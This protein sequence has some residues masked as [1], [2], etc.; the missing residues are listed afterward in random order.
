MSIVASILIRTGAVR[1]W[2]SYFASSA[3]VYTGSV[4]LESGN[5]IVLVSFYCS[6]CSIVC[7]SNLMNLF[8]V[9]LASGTRGLGTHIS[10]VRSV[11]MDQW[12]NDQ[13]ALMR[14]GGNDRCNAFL[15]S[16]GIITAVEPNAID[17][18]DVA[19]SSDA[20][21]QQPLIDTIR[22]KY[23]N[24][25]A[26]LYKQVLKAER[27]GLPIPTE[28]PMQTTKAAVI[29]NMKSKMVGFGS[30]PPPPTNNSEAPSHRRAMTYAV[31]AAIAVTGGV[32]ALVVWMLH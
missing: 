11:R 6:F 12:S 13:V 28:L 30:S 15:Q 32:V 2:A 27:D 4:L 7:T 10:F 14:L 26:Q 5:T 8:R 9:L 18:T 29:T 1:L 16:H 19:S 31:P 23:D 20:K 21:K 22:R 3:A 25:V 24:P 17:G